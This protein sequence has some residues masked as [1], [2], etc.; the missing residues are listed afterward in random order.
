M[1]TPWV[2][3]CY[4]N[5]LAYSGYEADETGVYK[6]MKMFDFN[7]GE[8]TT[9]I[10]QNEENKGYSYGDVSKDRIV[11]SL[12]LMEDL[13]LKDN[14]IYSYDLAE[15]KLGI[16]ENQD[17]LA[18]PNTSGQ[19]ISAIERYHREKM[20]D[21][22]YVLDTE[23]N[24][25]TRIIDHKTKIYEDIPE[26][27]T[28]GRHTVQMCGDYMVW[29]QTASDRLHVFNIRENTYYNILEENRRL[30]TICEAFENN[31]LVWADAAPDYSDVEYKY[32]ILK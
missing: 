3:S 22:I 13:E 27:S 15:R 32:A 25:W 23:L 4:D 28:M 12:S 7:T 19:Y 24:K 10:R 29:Q 6:A 14:I 21:C 2:L 1:P 8:L 17:N 5:I 26:S 30:I 11:F 20:E 16:I 9:L 18:L 31:M